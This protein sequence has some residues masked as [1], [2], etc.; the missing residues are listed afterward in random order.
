MARLR[1][2]CGQRRGHIS[3]T[4]WQKV[5]SAPASP[6]G[7]VIRLRHAIL[8]VSSSTDVVRPAQE[9]TNYSMMQYGVRPLSCVSLLGGM[10]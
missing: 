6:G 5:S 7:P 3:A 1:F 2:F 10:D 8:G 9:L 4:A